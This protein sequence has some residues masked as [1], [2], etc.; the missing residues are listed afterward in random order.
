MKKPNL[1]PVNLADIDFE[2]KSYIFTFEPLI[3]DMVH[4]IQSVGLINPPILEQRKDGKFRIVSGLK[5][6]IALK[7]LKQKKFEAKVFI[8]KDDR[9]DKDLFFLN[10][11]ENIA[12]RD[13][14][15]V[16]KAIVLKKLSHELKINKKK[17]IEHFL[18]LL[19][20][21]K[22]PELLERYLLLADFPDFLKA[23]L[24][25]ET[26]SLETAQ[27]LNNLSQDEQS[28]LF[29]L[30][31]ELKIGKNRQK[32]ILR[33]LNE[34]KHITDRE[35]L[36]ILHSDK[37]QD[38]IKNEKLTP[39]VKVERLVTF[40]KKLRYPRYSKTEE[41]F[42]SL[43]KELK[44]PPTIRLSPPPFFEGRKFR[45]EFTFS[46]QKEFNHI[47]TTLMKI[48]EKNE[49]KPLEDLYQDD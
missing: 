19:R 34:I 41:K 16:E 28:A 9:I 24:L 3:S 43:K 39:P 13:I 2:D 48:K 15:V 44:L 23:A 29:S 38:I 42:L 35:P 26:M 27:M 22:N 5:R 46:S 10:L 33:L 36:E 47:L 1:K 25:E 17:I 7:H 37:V 30:F 45:L 21:G 31:Q 12:T 40:L 6:I 14:N 20:L 8:S 32:E 49:L 18:P 4:S 11:H